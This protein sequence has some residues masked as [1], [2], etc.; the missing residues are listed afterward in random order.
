M[1]S[2]ETTICNLALGKIGS[3]RIMSLDDAT[4]PA[5][6]CKLFYAQGRDEVLRSHAWNFATQR[7]TLSQ[8]AAAPA[9]GWGYQYQLPT[10]CLRV[11]QLNA[12][13]D[14]Q[15]RPPYVVEQGKLLTDQDTANILYTARVEDANLFDPLFIKALSI[16]IASDIVTPLTGSRAQAAELMQEFEGMLKNLAAAQDAKEDRPKRKAAWVESDLV[17]ARF[18]S[19]IG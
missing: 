14:R 3:I 16:K 5:R 8:L 13:E 18:V 17:N 6:Y 2:D 1:A 19:D 7:A 12:F 15:I 4:Q 10:D 11:L 9:F